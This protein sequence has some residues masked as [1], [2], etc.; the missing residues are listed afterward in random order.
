MG[1]IKQILNQT[2][3]KLKIIMRRMHPKLKKKSNVHQQ[4]NNHKL[5]KLDL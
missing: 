4:T 1:L 2:Q 5:L 3:A